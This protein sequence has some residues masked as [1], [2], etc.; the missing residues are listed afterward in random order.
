[1]KLNV[2]ALGKWAVAAMA[3]YFGEPAMKALLIFLILDYVTGVAAAFVRKELCS[4]IGWR[5]LVK[6]C[7]IVLLV[8]GI[9]AAE[10]FMPDFAGVQ[11]GGMTLS[12]SSAAAAGYALNE[13]ISLV[14]NCYRAGIP[15]P[16][17]VVKFLLSAKKVFGQKANAGQIAELG[18]DARP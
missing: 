3:A 12:L 8:F 13:A 10:G 15:I 5:G 14:E 1:M 11:I 2:P 9:R 7:M 6:K 16:E 18:E 17:F 4:E